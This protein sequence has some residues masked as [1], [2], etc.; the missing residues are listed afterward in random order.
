MNSLN[1][2]STIGTPPPSPQRSRTSSASDI[3]KVAEEDKSWPSQQLAGS[4]LGKGD[5]PTYPKGDDEHWQSDE[6]GSYLDE[7]TPLLQSIRTGEDAQAVGSPWWPQRVAGAMVG[8][9]RIVL[10]T[11]FA[12]GRYLVACFYDDEG[13]F[14]AMMPMRR[15]GRAFTGRRTPQ[16]VT[17]PV[18]K[19]GGRLSRRSSRAKTK[20]E[21]KR[22]P[23]IVSATTAVT[24]DSESERPST[25]DGYSDWDGPAKNTRAKSMS[26]TS[27]ADGDEIAPARKSIRIKLHNEEASRQRRA[28]RKSQSMSKKP[29]SNEEVTEAAAAALKSPTSPLGLAGAKPTRYPRAPVPPRPL[30]PRRQ[31][32]YSTNVAA[33]WG[34][35]HQKTLILDLDETLIHSMSKGGRF[36]TG[37][38]VE[39]KLNQPIGV[40]G[41]VIGPQVPI[42]YYVHK[43]PHCDEFLRKVCTSRSLRDGAESGPADTSPHRSVSG[44]ISWFLPLVCK[45]TPTRSSTGWSWNASI[46]RHGTTAN[47]AH[48]VTAHISRTLRRSNPISAES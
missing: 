5:D 15:I 1:I 34:P 25:R 4:E 36:T 39:V 41:G 17:P 13:R 7:K 23:S 29:R 44:T 37:H 14:S 33:P 20:R 18:E 46:S 42:L 28:H 45:N 26:L 10:S 40:G 38:M 32:S 6:S 30:I 12:P 47:I 31:P 19:S 11:I 8:T 43:R 3:T 27:S 21:P 35:Q 9:I 48:S 22:S 16:V 24:S 2:L